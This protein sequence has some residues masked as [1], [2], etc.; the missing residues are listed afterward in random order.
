MQCM[1]CVMNAC[2][3]MGDEKM[4]QNIDFPLAKLRIKRTMHARI[5]PSETTTPSSSG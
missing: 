4:F 2:E 5:A 1:S 3:I